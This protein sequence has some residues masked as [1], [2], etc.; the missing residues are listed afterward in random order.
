LGRGSP[1]AYKHITPE[2]LRGFRL[3]AVWLPI[4]HGKERAM[5][6]ETVKGIRF[7]ENPQIADRAAAL[8]L[9]AVLI[10]AA[11][12]ENIFYPLEALKNAI[13]KEVI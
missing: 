1:W 5:K 11:F 8:E 2:A 10:K 6:I 3:G 9:L 12:V 4:N 13:E 7:E